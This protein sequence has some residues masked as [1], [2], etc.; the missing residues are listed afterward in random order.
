MLFVLWF[1]PEKEVCEV[2]QEV[3]GEALVA[4]LSERPLRH[5]LARQQGPERICWNRSQQSSAPANAMIEKNII[6][7]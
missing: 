1:K 2:R 3:D 4:H 6:I 5:R 7:F